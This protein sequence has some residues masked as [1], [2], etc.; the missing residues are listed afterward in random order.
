MSLWL[1]PLL[2]REPCIPLLLEAAPWG[3]AHST[4]RPLCR[5]GATFPGHCH[6]RFGNNPLTLCARGQETQG[7][8][9][10]LAR[11]PLLAPPH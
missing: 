9:A 11:P 8:L 7:H 2:C 3:Q 1:P 4:L 5:L 6:T 10:S